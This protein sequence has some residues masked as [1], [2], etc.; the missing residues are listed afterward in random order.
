M[1][2]VKFLQKNCPEALRGFEEMTRGALRTKYYLLLKVNS[3]NKELIDEAI[4]WHIKQTI[5]DSYDE[6]IKAM[7]KGGEL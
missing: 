3:D 7:I 2:S 5:G 1:D 6:G 4:M